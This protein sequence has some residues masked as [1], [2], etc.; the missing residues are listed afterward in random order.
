[1]F[2]MIII[3]SVVGSESPVRVP[4]SL[5]ARR[6]AGCPS[7]LALPPTTVTCLSTSR[8]RHP[9]HPAEVPSPF[10]IIGVYQPHDCA[11]G[12]PHGHHPERWAGRSRESSWPSSSP[13]RTW[14]SSPCPR[15]PR[16]RPP[17][18]RPDQL[19][20]WWCFFSETVSDCTFCMGM[21]SL[22]CW[23]CSGPEPRKGVN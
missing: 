11:P 19:F 9:H 3:L 5:R 14:A 18:G 12:A 2:Q 10:K 1:M 21:G 15:P 6:L 4:L 17:T 23:M 16:S 8:R 22:F 7:R 20:Y 13:T